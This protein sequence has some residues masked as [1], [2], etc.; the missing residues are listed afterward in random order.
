[1]STPPD[2]L[3]RLSTQVLEFILPV[4][5][6]APVGCHSYYV[7]SA[8]KWEIALFASRTEIVGGPADGKETV[9]K[10]TVDVLGLSQLFTALQCVEW[11]THRVGDEDELGS[12][13]CIDGFYEGAPVCLRLLAE[14][15]PQFQP[16]RLIYFDEQRIENVW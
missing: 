4:D 2:W 5:L 11:Q 9:S 14:S 8:D 12:H 16:G 13:L 10:F 3:E 15:P 6:L 1:M 7:E